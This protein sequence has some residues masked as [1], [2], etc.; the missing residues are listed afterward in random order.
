MIPTNN[1]L[2]LEFTN[3]RHRLTQLPDQLTINNDSI[4]NDR[5]MMMKN[6]IRMNLIF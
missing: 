6:K 4:R 5:A 2:V 1:N 3:N